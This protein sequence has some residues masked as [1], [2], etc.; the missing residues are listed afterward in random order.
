TNLYA[1]DP[2]DWHEV[3]IVLKADPSG[4]GTHEA[5]V[6]VD[7]NLSPKLFHMTAGAS[8]GSVDPS[9]LNFGTA[10]TFIAIASPSTGQSCAFD[11]DF[12]D[13]KIG[14][15]YP[16]GAINLLPPQIQVNTP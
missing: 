16:A 1:L 4:R 15:F 8:E 14:E 12:L 2:T 10:N 6:F 7:G 9:G 5:Y 11:L 13:Y 3:W